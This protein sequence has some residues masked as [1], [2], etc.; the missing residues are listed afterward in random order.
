MVDGPPDKDIIDATVAVL[1]AWGFSSDT[2]TVEGIAHEIDMLYGYREANRSP[3]GDVEA[4][5]EALEI[6][7]EM[8]IRD[9]T[10]YSSAWSIRQA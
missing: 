2:L 3:S 7:E 4:L 8:A 5:R 6:V 9:P 10:P 1:N